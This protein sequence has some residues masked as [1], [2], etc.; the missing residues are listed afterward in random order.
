MKQVLVSFVIC[1][2]LNFTIQ[3]Q[4]TVGIG[5]VLNADQQ[6]IEDASV[7][8]GQF[9]SSTD[10]RGQFKIIA[11]YLPVQLLINHP[12]YELYEQI[13]LQQTGKDTIFLAIT[14]ITESTDLEEDRKRRQNC[15]GL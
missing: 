3:A 2:C 6:P 10:R 12:F 11:N 13:V 7:Q 14:L 8:L 1:C 5:T 4:E 15:V 9:F